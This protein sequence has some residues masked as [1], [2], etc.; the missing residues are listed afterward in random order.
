MMIFEDLKKAKVASL[1]QQH[2]F[3]LRRFMIIVLVTMCVQ[4]PNLQ[5][6][7]YAALSLVNLAYLITV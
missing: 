3:L 6:T 4:Y 2:V 5:S 7:G 1:S